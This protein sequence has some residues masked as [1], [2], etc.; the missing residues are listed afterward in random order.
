MIKEAFHKEDITLINIYVP[1]TGAQKHVK[2]L[3]TDLKREIGS[4]TIKIGDPNSPLISM[5]RS[6]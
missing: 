4:N 1:K 6:I 3:L 5:G 2:Q